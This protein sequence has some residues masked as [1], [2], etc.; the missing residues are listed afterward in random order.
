MRRYMMFLRVM[1]VIGVTELAVRAIFQFFHI[2]EGLGE[3][4]ANAGLLVV[5]CAPP[6]YFWVARGMGKALAD[7]H[8]RDFMDTAPDLVQSVNPQ[9]RFLYVNHAWLE[10]LGYA[11]EEFLGLS[12][13]DIIHPDHRKA[14]QAL[15]QRILSGETVE[16]IETVFVTKD[17]RSVIVSGNINCRFEGG[18]PV[19]TRGI[20]RNITE[21]KRAEAAIVVSEQRYADLFENA[22]D[23]IFTNDV[24]GRFTAANRAAEQLTGYRREE[25]VKLTASQLVSPGL[26]EIALNEVARM[27]VGGARPATQ[28]WEIITKDGRACRWKP[29]CEPSTTV[30][31]PSASRP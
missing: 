29:V 14:C 23:A 26:E 25:I 4:I 31:R 8:L 2:P 12:M 22:Q 28:E 13:L 3:D 5:L 6:L 18:K 21:S 1:V 9:G 30:T 19:A 20:F 17:G 10:T 27:S 11:R 24:S 15:F 16:N 7:E